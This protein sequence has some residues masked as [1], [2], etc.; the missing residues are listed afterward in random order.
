MTHCNKC[1]EECSETSKFCKSCG[2]EVG[3]KPRGIEIVCMSCGIKNSIFAKFCKDCGGKLYKEVEKTSK[4]KPNSKTAKS[5]GTSFIKEES[6]VKE[7]KYSSNHQKH[8]TYL[9]IVAII[10]AI[11]II[12]FF[13]GFLGRTGPTCR[14]Y[15]VEKVGC[16]KDPDCSCTNKALFGYGWC[17]ECSCKVCIGD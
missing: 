3:K 8:K 17:D 9:G 13:V 14:T 11:L 12:L 10:L 2:H 15:T 4:E 6:N 7:K 16:D 5:C 1:G